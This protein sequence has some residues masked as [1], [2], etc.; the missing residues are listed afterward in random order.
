MSLAFSIRHAPSSEGSIPRVVRV[1]NGN[2]KLSS[3]EESAFEIAGWLTFKKA[4]VLPIC[5]RSSK[6]IIN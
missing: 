4:A 2:P 5:L 6:A 3:N 1:N